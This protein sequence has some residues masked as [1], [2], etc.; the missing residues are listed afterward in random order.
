[1]A[2]AGAIAPLVQLLMKE[3][4]YRCG[5]AMLLDFIAYNNPQHGAEIAAAGAI[6]HL[7]DLVC[8]G[9][10]DEKYHAGLALRS[11]A[12]DNT[13]PA[14]NILAAGVLNDLVSLIFSDDDLNMAGASA[15]GILAEM[16]P[17]CR[18][19]IGGSGE[20][21]WLTHMLIHG[22]NCTKFASAAALCALAADSQQNVSAILTA[23]AVQPLARLL[24]HGD[25]MQKVVA[26][27]LTLSML[28]FTTKK[29]RIA[30]PLC[31][32]S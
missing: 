31:L 25:S 20:I 13:R 23:G 2:E 27:L 18:I 3:V 16:V 32:S 11:I 14:V 24:K 8:R 4:N 9:D 21:E 19:D 28:S 6:E 10:D 5:Y 12:T 29:S 7:V 17:A 1:M 30:L 22:G 26:S 15:L